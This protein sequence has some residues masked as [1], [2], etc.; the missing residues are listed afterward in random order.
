VFFSVTIA[1]KRGGPVWE[2]SVI[3]RGKG[4]DNG[5]IFPRKILV[6]LLA[7]RTALDV[8]SIPVKAPL[9]PASEQECL[10]LSIHKTSFPK[11]CEQLFLELA[12]PVKAF[13]LCNTLPI[14]QTETVPDRTVRFFREYTHIRYAIARFRLLQNRRGKP[15]PF[16]GREEVTSSIHTTIPSAL[17]TGSQNR[18]LAKTFLYWCRLPSWSG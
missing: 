12:F 5:F 10:G 6:L 17:N 15:Y 14:P 13:R 4:W 3:G 8:H 9:F 2:I 16:R 1:L 18:T 7:G 11:V